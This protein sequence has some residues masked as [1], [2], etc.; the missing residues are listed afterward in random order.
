MIGGSACLEKAC[1]VLAK[2]FNLL[3]VGSIPTAFT[4][5][6]LGFPGLF[7]LASRSFTV[8]AFTQ[9]RPSSP[10]WLQFGFTG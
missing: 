9:S 7:L 2:S 5:K 10:R 4:P 1:E 8:Q 3:V 6:A